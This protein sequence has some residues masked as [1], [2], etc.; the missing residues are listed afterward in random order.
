MI[1]LSLGS[2]QVKRLAWKNDLIEKIEKS[3]EMAPIMLLPNM[4]NSSAQYLSIIAEGKF[5]ETELHVL[6]SLKPYGPGFKLVKPFKL[7]SN[8]VIMIDLGF[9]QEKNKNVERMFT[10][11]R[12]VGNILYPN[13]TDSF[14]PDPNLDRNI[15][16]SRNVTDMS[17][18][19]KTRPIM[20][21]LSDHIGEGVIP[22]PLKP[23]LTNNHL[24]YAIT[25]FS[26]ALVW[27][28][29]S[30]Y[31]IIRVVKKYRETGGKHA[32]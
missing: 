30:V 3:I 32:L 25:W 26:M 2:W 5:L 29:M 19:M 10:S 24:Q 14:T 21:V 1:L 8:E 17:N 7:L 4:I 31:L 16:F 11:E 18:Y 23:N 9:I 13:E 22:T 12:I 28:F 27:V 15:W 20:V 6:H